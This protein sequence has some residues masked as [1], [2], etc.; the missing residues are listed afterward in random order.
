MHLWEVQMCVP[1]P[2]PGC[3]SN[4]GITD[5]IFASPQNAYVKALIP[6]MVVFGNGRLWEVIRVRVGHKG[7]VL[8]MGVVDLKEEE[9]KNY[10][11]GLKRLCED[12]V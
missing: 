8:M 12:V 4:A 9:D 6:N 7:R 2:K 10:P 3:L 11:H 1:S 5:W